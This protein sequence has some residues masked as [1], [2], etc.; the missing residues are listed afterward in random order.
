MAE[1]I[2]MPKLGFDMREAVLLN[3]LKNE[4]DEVKKGDIV[5]E[6]ES[7]KATLELESQVSGTLLKYLVSAGDVA[8]IGSNLAVVGQPGE[9]VPAAEAAGGK[10][11]EAKV[12][13]TKVESPAKTDRDEAGARPAPAQT[14]GQPA[15]APAA[16]PAP[17]TTAAVSGEYPAGVKATPVARRMAQEQEVD[18][19]QV[20]G[21]GPDGRIR[22]ADVET[23]LQSGPKA[24]PA[25][26]TAAATPVASGP[27][28]TEVATTRL[29]QAI[30]R[31]MVESK[32]TV[33]HFYV[34]SEIDMAPAVTLRQQINALLPEDHKV[35]INDMIV[36]AAALALREFPNLNAG[37]AGD[38]IVRHNRINV[39]SAVAVEGGLMTVVQKDTDKTPLAQVAA[40][41]KAMI[42][43]ARS[44][45]ISPNDVT[46]G[47]FTVSN[48][49]PFDVENFIAIINPPEAAILAVGSS[50]QVPVVVDGQLTVGTRMKVTISADHRVTDG[51][52]AA[53]YMQAFKKILEEPMRLLL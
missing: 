31:R 26:A 17:E 36:K 14:S 48:L 35:S 6:I 30:A 39:G 11:A 42:A 19:K 29:R 23:F 51:A 13:D 22:R 15:E 45:K 52:E 49:G 4:G 50:R 38:K 32:T 25:P 12:V 18:L 24:A 21:S 9:D 47:T 44:G 33:P 5:A 1:Y 28:T 20:S 46:D 8:A 16:E 27:D 41:N 3:W 7:D 34:T 43:R 2:V 53:R 40:D 10:P 37:F